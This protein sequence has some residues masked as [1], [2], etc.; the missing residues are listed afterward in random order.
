MDL[1][2]DILSP[3]HQLVESVHQLR[4]P[5][6]GCP[7]SKEQT[8]ES[9]RSHLI[10]E[11][12]EVLDILD[13]THSPKELLENTALRNAFM[14][15]LGDLLMQILMHIEIASES[16]AFNLNDIADALNN[17]IIR[18]HPHVFG[19][20]SATDVLS[21]WETQ[22]QKENPSK[23]TFLN[24]PKKLPSLQR[25][26]RILEKANR[27]G[28]MNSKQPEKLE[29]LKSENIGEILLSICTFAY[30]SQVD[31]E[32]ALRRTLQQLEKELLEKKI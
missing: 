13:Q 4:S 32:S 17:K 30:L 20:A 11:A 16:G 26:F 19:N 29:P 18:R 12:Y 9:L 3:L 15:E 14:E 24:I 1:E 31:P 25:A 27:M 10:E 8:H 6:K 23:N 7:W 21:N 5:E 28:L 22:K 2:K